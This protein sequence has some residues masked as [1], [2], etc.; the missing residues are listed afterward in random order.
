MQKAVLAEVVDRLN[1]VSNELI[2]ASRQFPTS[3]THRGRQLSAWSERIRLETEVIRR[4]LDRDDETFESAFAKRKIA[5]VKSVIA[6][7]V[8]ASS[9]ISGV[10][11][12]PDAATVSLNEIVEVGDGLVEFIDEHLVDGE[13]GQPEENESSSAPPRGLSAL[14][15]EWAWRLSQE[16][17]RV[18]GRYLKRLS[19]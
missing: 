4:E 11:D 18:A 17:K 10:A 1:L 6:G 8:V 3:L 5:G 2:E 14:G 16:P 15:L 19:E 7:L 9:L 13:E 12:L